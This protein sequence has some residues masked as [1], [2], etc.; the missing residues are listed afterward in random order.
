MHQFGTEANRPFPNS[1]TNCARAAVS[2]RLLA[3][4]LVEVHTV[5]IVFDFFDNVF[6]LL[7]LPPPFVL[8]HLCLFAEELHVGL[9]VAAEDTVRNSSVLAVAKGACQQAWADMKEAKSLLVVEV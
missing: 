5:I 2:L 6:H 4:R 1:R 3:V 9:A 8:A 7:L